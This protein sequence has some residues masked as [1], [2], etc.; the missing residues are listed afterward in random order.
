[1]TDGITEL[2][3]SDD[4]DFMAEWIYALWGSYNPG[5]TLDTCRADLLNGLSAD[6]SIPKTFVYRRGATLVGWVSILPIDI[7]ERPDLGPWL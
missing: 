3:P 6:V 7:E 2:L 5:E 1:M 4:I